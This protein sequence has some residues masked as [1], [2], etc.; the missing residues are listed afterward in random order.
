MVLELFPQSKKDVLLIYDGTPSEI[1]S[2]QA[3]IK[4]LADGIITEFLI[5]QLPYVKSIQGC[6]LCFR[7]G[8]NLGV[9]RIGKDQ[10]FEWVL[11]AERW[12]DIIDFLEPLKE[13]WR[14]GSCY[15]EQTERLQIIAS[16]SRGW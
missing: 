11:S 15:L 8:K 1:V 5:D 14:G 3:E 13:P 10:S 7:L 12:N 16:S 6:K 9:K 2:L 4:N